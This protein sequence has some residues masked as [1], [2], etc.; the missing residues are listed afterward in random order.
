[1]AAQ[2][3]KKKA[4]DPNEKVIASN[5]RARFQYEVLDTLGVGGMGT[6]YRARVTDGDRGLPVGEEVALK[7]VHPQLLEQPAA[8]R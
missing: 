8:K 5:R 2:N 7:V 6:V 1:M 3:P 4:N